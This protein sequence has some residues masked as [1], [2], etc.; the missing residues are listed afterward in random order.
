MWVLEHGCDAGMYI[1]VVHDVSGGAALYCFKFV[2]VRGCM[3]VP[4]DAKMGR[5]SVV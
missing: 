3:W 1:V 5:T 2:V 4:D